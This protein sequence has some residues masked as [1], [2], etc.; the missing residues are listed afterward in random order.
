MIPPIAASDL[1]HPTLGRAPFTA[2]GWLFELKHDGYRAL[3]IKSGA[4]VELLSRWGRS[5]SHA[6]PEIVAAVATLP[7]DAVL[8][9]ELVVPDA[10][11]RSDFAEL[12]RRALLQRP[13]MIAHAAAATP[14]ALV[15]FDVLHAGVDDM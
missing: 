9:A 5:M 2:E 14:A 13:R 1:C 6:F 15:V 11:G 3:V 8:D 12:R 4:R 7:G 10:A